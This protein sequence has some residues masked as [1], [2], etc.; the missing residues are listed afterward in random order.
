MPPH[1]IGWADKMVGSVAFACIFGFAHMQ[2]D[3]VHRKESALI[4][5][6]RC[7]PLLLTSVHSS[8]IGSIKANLCRNIHQIQCN[9]ARP[10]GRRPLMRTPP[11]SSW[12]STGPVRIQSTASAAT[13][14]KHTA[15]TTTRCTAMPPHPRPMHDTV[16]W[17]SI[18]QAAHPR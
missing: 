18:N 8:L 17:M 14:S 11:C 7:T 15:R 16:L 3:D 4:F 10:C 6:L 12:R 9:T 1:N 5:I 2:S 13:E